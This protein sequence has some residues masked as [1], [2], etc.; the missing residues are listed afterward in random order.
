MP[1][2]G[3][4]MTQSSKSL[5]QSTHVE[6]VKPKKVLS[7]YLCFTTTNVKTI[8]EKEGI[9]YSQGIK[10]AAELW[11]AMDEKAKQP[12]L[13]LSAQDQKR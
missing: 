6:K 5:A 8:V 11:N 7:P 9:T 1:A 13:K 4:A 10:R 3:S 12:Y 2:K